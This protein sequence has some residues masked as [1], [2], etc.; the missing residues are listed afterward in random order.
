M[1]ST[2]KKKILT[3]AI[4][5][6]ISLAVGGIAAFITRNN[7][8]IYDE[9]NKPVFSP[10]GFLFPVVWTVLYIL[11]GISSAMIW[12]C[13]DSFREEAESALLWYGGSLV[14]NFWWSP[15]FF[16]FRM[17]LFAFIILV[18]LLML[19]LKSAV[20]YKKLRPVAAYLQLPY[21]I[22]ICF[23]GYLNLAIYILNG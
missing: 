7:M 14:A 1:T 5:I 11:M 2:K 9:I 8:N 13:R 17:Y 18:I 21:I 22:W 3:Y 23:A 12:L 19:V 15:V 16:N 20:E 10:P 6:L 4:F